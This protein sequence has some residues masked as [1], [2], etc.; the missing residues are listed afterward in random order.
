MEIF[1]LGAPVAVDAVF[2][3]D[4]G[5]PT[6]I[7]VGGRAG[8]LHRLD[9]TVGDAAG[10]IGQPAIKRVADPCARRAD[11]ALLGL[12]LAA[13][14]GG[15]DAPRAGSA[16]LDA[17]PV[18]ISFDA[19]HDGTGLP[20]VAE[21]SADQSAGGI[22]I[23]RIRANCGIAP[24]RLAPGIAAIDAGIEAGPTERQLRWRLVVR[25]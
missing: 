17:H 13:A 5:G 16:A 15:T 6:D 12:A 14:I 11:P 1:E 25:R 2:Q 7:G 4:A 3:A 22:E 24:T 19:E 18:G 8:R 9:V 10:D 21:L 23:S 20:I